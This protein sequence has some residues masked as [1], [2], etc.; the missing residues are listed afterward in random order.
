MPRQPC[1]WVT[2]GG[3]QTTRP[4][5][6]CEM[7]RRRSAVQAIRGLGELYSPRKDEEDVWKAGITFFALVQSKDDTV[8]NTEQ[9]VCMYSGND[10][11]CH[12]ARFVQRC[13]MRMGSESHCGWRQ[14]SEGERRGVSA[15][16]GCS[17][18]LVPDIQP[19]TY[20]AA[21]G[22]AFCELRLDP[23]FERFT[24]THTHYSLFTWASA[25]L[26]LIWGC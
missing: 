17:S 25:D 21:A 8:T 20:P 5:D 7:W 19:A 1:T 13:Q 12:S 26:P 14:R 6:T 18:V 4:H 11:G 3:S 16:S 9:L 2:G 23:A 10:R 22:N 24:Q 15:L